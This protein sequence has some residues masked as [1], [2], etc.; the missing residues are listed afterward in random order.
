MLIEMVKTMFIYGNDSNFNYET[1]DNDESLDF[2][3][4]DN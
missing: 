1:V 3:I 4:I 2:V